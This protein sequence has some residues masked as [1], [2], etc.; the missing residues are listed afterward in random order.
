M[1]EIVKIDYVML[2]Y[3][4]EAFIGARVKAAV[5]NVNFAKTLIH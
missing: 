2:L 3:L 1:Y 5:G 4:S